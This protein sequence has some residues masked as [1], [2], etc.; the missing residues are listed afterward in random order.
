MAGRDRRTNRE[1]DARQVSGYVSEVWERHVKQNLVTMSN[2]LWCAGQDICKSAS[3]YFDAILV[4]H[5]SIVLVVFTAHRKVTKSQIK[6]FSSNVRGWDTA[7]TMFSVPL[8]LSEDPGR[9]K[10]LF[11]TLKSTVLGYRYS[12]NWELRVDIS[13]CIELSESENGIIISIVHTHVLRQG[14]LP[15]ILSFLKLILVCPQGWERGCDC[16]MI[17]NWNRILH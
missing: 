1:N 2:K 6:T 5:V 12:T 13:I 16:S 9:H 15:E 4:K 17:G 11:P 10:S 14:L 8:V 3:S 7:W